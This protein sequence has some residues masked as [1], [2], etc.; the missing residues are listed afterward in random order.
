VED[1]EGALMWRVLWLMAVLSMVASP[2]RS[3]SADEWV[4]RGH[5]AA[6]ENRHDAAIEAYG[7]A[8]A[9]NAAL[10]PEL[11]ASLGRQHLWADRPAH[12]AALLA[13]Y[14]AVRDD[15]DVRSDYGLALSWN[16]ELA[17]A[18]R[19]LERVI[20]ECPAAAAHARLR[21]ALVR[22]WQD[23]PTPAQQLYETAA[24]GGSR[25]DVRA[26]R[27][28]L[29]H[30]ALMRDYNRAALHEFRALAAE[31]PTGGE[32]RAAR[33]GEAIALARLGM[34]ASAG[35]LVEG[36]AAAGPLSRDLQEV[37]NL[38]AF[39]RRPQ[40]TPIVR[41]LRDADGMQLTVVGAAAGTGLGSRGRAGIEVTHWTLGN[42]GTDMSATR[43]AANAAVRWTAALAARGE[44]AGA[45][46][47]DGGWTPLTGE[48]NVIFTPTD[49]LRGDAAF[50]RLIVN[51]NIAAVQN[52]LIGSF[53]S[54]GADVRVAA[55]VTLAASVDGT[56]WST[57]NRRVRFRSAARWQR[58]G[59]PRLTL[60]LP[61]LVQLY[62]EPMPFAFF[63]PARYIEAGPGATVQWR[64]RR[65][66]S[67]SLYGRVGAQHETG[68]AWDPF[69]TAR[70]AARRDAI[71]DWSVQASLAWSN[72]NLASSTS[73]QRTALELSVT[74]A[75]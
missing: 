67:V 19:V 20:V 65:H 21:L 25:D 39:Q 69:G 72:S 6:R 1:P 33:E 31:A 52:R 32:A 5:E 46:V 12:A 41:A 2:A 38:I 14:L 42:G 10:R 28:G 27:L 75:F 62:D 61:V 63:S 71:R 50:A 15:C 22:R 34:H 51:D 16:D 49:R 7:R 54:M 53:L 11:L 64:V 73:F 68:G 48:L 35:D 43:L 8:I 44:L 3:Q 9:L 58:E 17:A 4:E 70:A 23:L 18:A 26:A 57:G 40:V 74:R 47:S 30:V 56:L 45:R 24:A 59:V 66:W 60:E 36:A 13:E 37:R 29:A 55:A